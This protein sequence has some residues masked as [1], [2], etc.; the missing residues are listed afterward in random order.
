MAC[1]Q[2]PD[3]PTGMPITRLGVSTGGHLLQPPGLWVHCRSALTVQAIGCQLP[4]APLHPSRRTGGPGALIGAHSST[5]RTG[6][7]RVRR[8]IGA[9]AAAAI[10]V[11]VRI[12]APCTGHSPSQA[13]G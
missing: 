2:H 7:S 10:A 5:V 12:G 9:T 4:P 11:S 6:K 3:E 13:P 8:A 1:F